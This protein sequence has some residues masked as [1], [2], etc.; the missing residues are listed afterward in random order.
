MPSK[1]GGI[2]L[3]EP[4][5]GSKFGGVPVDDQPMGRDS[6]YNQLN[7]AI[8]PEHGGLVNDATAVLGELAASANRS[9]TE[10]VD[11]VGPDTVNA[12]LRLSG[13]AKQV[14]TLTGALED[15]G[16]Q[17]GFMKPGIARDAVRA[18]GQALTMAGGLAPV[19][20]NLAKTGP[21]IAEFVGMGSAKVPAAAGVSLS[22]QALDALPPKARA[23]VDGTGDNITAKIKLDPRAPIEAPRII[24]DKVGKEAVKQGFD[25]GFVAM[26]KTSPKK[27][28]EKMSAMIDIMEKG[29]KNFRY[30]ANNRALDVTGESVLDRVRVVREANKAAGNRLDHVA[31][32]LK[33]QQVDFS[34]AVD[35]F[36]GQIDDMGIK[37]DPKANKVSFSDSDLEGLTGVQRTV[38]NVLNRM[39]NT[40][41]PDAYDI[42]RMKRFIDEQVTY[43]KNAGG[44]GGKTERILKTLRHDLDSI[45]DQNFPEYNKVN[46]QYAETISALDTFQDV[47][48]KKMDLTG[49]NADKAVGTLTRRLLSNAQ[50]RIPLKDAISELDQVAKK[51]VTPGGTDIVPYGHITKK[52]GI[53]LKDL[54]DDIMGQVL[55]VD[56][57]EKILG[58]SARTSLL[59]DIDKGVRT[60]AGGKAGAAVEGAS[61]AAKK[62]AGINEEKA[63]KAIR[64]LMEST[65]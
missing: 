37:F 54:D 36:L 7:G 12:I 52:A 21:A 40:K 38:K 31:G 8:Q 46:T 30:S 13:S 57:L 62:L 32:S 9:V 20:R 49:G 45:L 15:T 23:L 55:F 25:E 42:H 43:G 53:A 14:P 51:F 2:P 63:I 50:S 6:Y 26:V 1:Y 47:A 11:F 65:N 56:E 24:T 27:G 29:K 64:E 17:G 35:S 44:L 41:S 10:F 18:G 59:G 61:M 19:T 28:R 58:P 4:A 5:T 16:I 60:A 3:D 22:Q 33:G 48:G 34:P 39:R